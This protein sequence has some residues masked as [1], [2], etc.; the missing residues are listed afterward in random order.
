MS[1][2]YYDGKG[3]RN[4]ELVNL[5]LAINDSSGR[6]YVNGVD[7]KTGRNHSKAVS[8]K[9]AKEIFGLTNRDLVDLKSTALADT[10]GANNPHLEPFNNSDTFTYPEPE[11][12]PET[13]TLSIVKPKPK[14]KIKNPSGDGAYKTKVYKNHERDYDKLIAQLQQMKLAEQKGGFNPAMIGPVADAAGKAAEGMYGALNTGIDALD[15]QS[16]RGFE[17][18]QMTGWYNRKKAR[19]DR[20][21]GAKNMKQIAKNIKYIRQEWVKEGGMKMTDDEIMSAAIAMAQGG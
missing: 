3:K 15:K 10:S 2:S 7:S 6:L 21:S 14:A 11:L 13:Q 18:N 5:S 1:I 4:R 8:K 19:N 12:P 9:E 20:R 17:K 16:Q